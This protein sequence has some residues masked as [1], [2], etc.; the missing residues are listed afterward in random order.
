MGRHRP[1]NVTLPDG[2]EFKLQS[3]RMITEQGLSVAEAARRLG[4]RDNQLRHG[5]KAAEQKGSD[6]FPGRAT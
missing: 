4:V 5:K 3:L 2:K 1:S 6:A